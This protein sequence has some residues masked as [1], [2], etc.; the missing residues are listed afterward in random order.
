[1]IIRRLIHCAVT[2]A[3]LGLSVIL[4]GLPSLHKNALRGSDKIRTTSLFGGNETI[5][6]ERSGE[7]NSRSSLLRGGSSAITRHQKLKSQ[8]QSTPRQVLDLIASLNG[9][10][11][12]EEEPCVL[13]SQG[14]FGKVESEK[15][16]Y[17]SFFY[18]AIFASGTSPLEVAAELLP[19]LEEE[20]TTG[21]LPILFDCPTNTATSFIAGVSKRLDDSVTSSV[22]CFQVV[23][24]ECYSFQ[25]RMLFFS[26]DIAGPSDA[27]FVGAEIIKNFLLTDRLSDLDSRILDVSYIFR[28]GGSRTFKAP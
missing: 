14:T 24:G 26:N 2:A 1:M 17:V 20:I 7:K 12:N 22:P 19:L 13:N 6:F 4:L 18:Q 9:R 8:D 21:I 16:H 3:I 11:L 23:Q 25:G 15:L 28:D 27:Q 10:H 5:P